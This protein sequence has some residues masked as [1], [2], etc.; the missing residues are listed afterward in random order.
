M[1]PPFAV[2]DYRR[3]IRNVLVDPAI[4]GRFLRME[5]GE[6]GPFHSHDLGEEIFLVL[7]G[8]AEF[9]IEGHVEVLG[10]GQ[11]CVARTDEK[12]EVRVVGD[13]P[14]TLFLS[15]TPHLEPTHTFWDDQGRKLPPRYGY[16]TP[17]GL[18][19]WSMPAEPPS[20]LATTYAAATRRLAETLATYV[21][22]QSEMLSSV[23]DGT[24]REDRSENKAAVDALWERMRV[25]CQQFTELE[26][27]WNDLAV[28]AGS[29]DEGA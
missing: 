23:T 7:E 2:Y 10:P 3:D 25:I 27:A 29:D 16:W 24:A 12:H 6:I 5:P 22:E 18:A 17:A 13:Q 11:M 8:Q 14:M 19:E 20:A 15:V 28:G 26:R 9:E 21:D 1:T 4:R